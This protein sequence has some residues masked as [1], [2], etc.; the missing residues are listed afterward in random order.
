MLQNNSSSLKRLNAMEFGKGKLILGGTSQQCGLTTTQFLIQLS[1]IINSASATFYLNGKFSV[2]DSISDLATADDI[3]F[4]HDRYQRWKFSSEGQL[5]FYCKENGWPLPR[6][7]SDLS[8]C[9][10]DELDWASSLRSRHTENTKML[11]LSEKACGI[12]LKEFDE[13]LHFSLHAELA[14]LLVKSTYNHSKH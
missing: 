1:R 12:V 9:Q 11:S 4:R 14:P 5:Y 8:F 6:I 7:P 13:C 3:I 10:R 2:P